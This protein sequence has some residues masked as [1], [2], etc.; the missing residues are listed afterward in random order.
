MPYGTF[1]PNNQLATHSFAE[2]Q[3]TAEFDDALVDQAAWKNS[4][5]DGSKLTAA[6]INKFTVGDSSYQNEPVITNQ[7]TALYIANTVIGGKEDP[8]FASIKNHSYVGINKILLIDSDNETV[9]V[10]DKATEPFTE[11]QRFITNDFPTGNKVFTKI[12]DE[13]IQTN[14]KGHHRVKMNKGFLLKTLDFEF[15][16]EFS[17]SQ[18]V[19]CLT[20]N[21]SMYLYRKGLFKDNFII[22][23]SIANPE[24]SFIS[25]SNA[26]RFRYGYMEMFE[27]SDAGIS[28]HKTVEHSRIGPLFISSSI[29]ENQFTLQY[30]SGSLGFGKVFRN[31]G[32]NNPNDA[33]KFGG[34]SLGS[35]SRFI[36]DTLSFLQTN[37]AD[38]SLTQQEKTELHVT[39]FEGAKDFAPGFNDERSIGTFEVDQNIGNLMVE[40][41]D[42]CNDF[43]PTNHELIFKGTNDGRFL[44]TL[45]TFEDEIQ[46]A[47]I[48][49]SSRYSPVGVSATTHHLVNDFGINGEFGCNP[50]YDLDTTTGSFI[51][52]GVTV[53]RIK[54]DCIVQGGAVGTIGFISAQTGSD[55]SAYGKTISGSMTTDNFYSGSFSYEISFLKKDHTLIL[56]LDKDSE[57]FDGI[58]NQGLVLIPQDADAQVAFNV[59]Y[60]LAQAGIINSSPTITQNT[61]N[62]LPPGFS[63]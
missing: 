8:Q 60:Y 58:G 20:E 40:Q 19:D 30:Y 9:Q 55:S 29:I 12:I 36:L 17:G 41:G 24:P 44:P 16:G 51:H 26:L 45:G 14:L 7:T 5:Y 63:T 46:N 34:S 62:P 3:L 31:Q 50:P 43:L 54:M 53:D 15:A 32:E 4:R 35:G 22:T 25:Q 11:F 57:L 47:H 28:G 49:S 52:G 13:S 38:T 2:R 37:I 1:L 61:T 48:Q 10:I 6:S 27:G 56:D 18:Q 39:F 21:N 42:I 59:E 33:E 23:G